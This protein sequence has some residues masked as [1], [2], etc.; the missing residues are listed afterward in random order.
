M[1]IKNVTVPVRR[2]VPVL[3]LLLTLIRLRQARLLQVVLTAREIRFTPGLATEPAGRTFP[4]NHQ[5]VPTQPA[6]IAP[7]PTISAGRV[8]PVIINPAI[9][10]KK[11]ADRVLT[12]G[13]RFIQV[14]I[15]TAA[16]TAR[17]NPAIRNA[18]V[19]VVV[20][21]LALPKDIFLQNRQVKIVQLFRFVVLHAIIIVWI[22]N[23]PIRTLILVRAV[24]LRPTLGEVR[25]ELLPKPVPV[26]NLPER[27]MLLPVVSE[28]ARQPLRLNRLTVRTPLVPTVREHI[29]PVGVAIRDIM[30]QAVPVL[31]M[32]C[33]ARYL[34]VPAP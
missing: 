1:F 30:L 4:Q 7:V 33:P 16:P 13:V 21:I 23:L 9:L 22:R 8:T 24:I 29:I 2:P 28:P 25:L 3:P 32:L 10:A 26:V 17:L 18:A 15:Q 20:K 12:T 19:P 6:Q 5:T 14:V 31:K 34:T 11:T 27:A